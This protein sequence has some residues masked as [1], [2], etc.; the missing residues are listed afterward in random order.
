VK[1]EVRFT[2]GQSMSKLD[3][4]TFPESASFQTMPRFAL[5]AALFGV[6]GNEKSGCG[7]LSRV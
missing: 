3:G 6:N 4:A 2:P 1:C 5:S 7:T